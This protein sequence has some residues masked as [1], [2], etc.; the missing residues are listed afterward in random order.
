MMA[1]SQQR[2]LCRVGGV[3]RFTLRA[4]SGMFNNCCCISFV[5]QNHKDNNLLIII[6]NLTIKI[7]I[8]ITEELY[9]NCPPTICMCRLE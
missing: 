8:I 5:F 3:C 7:V 2:A 9:R 4:L 6:I 1:S